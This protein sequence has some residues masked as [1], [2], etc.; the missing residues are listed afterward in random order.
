MLRALFAQ[1]PDMSVLMKEGQHYCR[2]LPNDRTARTRRRLFALHQD[3]YRWTKNDLKRINH[4]KIRRAFYKRWDTSKPFL[5]EKSPQHMLRMEFMAEAFKPAVFIGII[6]N[7]YA[8]AEGLKRR[9]N[10]AVNLGAKQWRLANEI[11]LADS[12]KV[13]FHLVSYEDVCL[14]PQRVFDGICQFLG[15]KSTTLDLE[16]PMRRQ[17]L[18]GRKVH[19]SMVDAPD[20]NHESVIRLSANE[21][22]IIRQE[23]G[24]LLARFGYKPQ[25]IK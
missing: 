20:F 4:G 7:G 18:Y 9:R 3:V 14:D 15:A 11:M 23:A 17:N 6:R 13:P 25:G 12:S 19:F 22:D 21:I 8:V 1:H 5:V 16:S 10:H 2:V 24:P